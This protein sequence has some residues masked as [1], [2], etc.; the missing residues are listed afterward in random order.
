M[1]VSL[2]GLVSGSMLIYIE[3]EYIIIL[4]KCIKW[5]VDTIQLDKNNHSVET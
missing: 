3:I 4:C 2:R 5:V 1:G